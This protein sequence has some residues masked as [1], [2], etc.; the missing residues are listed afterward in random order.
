MFAPIVLN[1]V[2]PD[3]SPVHGDPQVI[4]KFS[5]GNPPSIDP[6]IQWTSVARGKKQMTLAMTLSECNAICVEGG[7]SPWVGENV[8]EN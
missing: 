8:A 6:K 1:L 4:D 7:Q 2:T 3:Q 5:P